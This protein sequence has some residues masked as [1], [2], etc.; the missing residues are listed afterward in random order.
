MASIVGFAAAAEFSTS[1]AAD[2]CPRLAALRNK[3]WGA[4][5]KSHPDSIRNGDTDRSL[6]NTLNVSFPGTDGEALLIGLDLEGVC[7]SSGSACMVGSIRASH[8]LLAMGVPSPTALATV[9]F[10]LGPSTTD[11][12]IEQAARSMLRVLEQQA[13]TVP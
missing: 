12:D 6:S 8:V 10:S 9:R 5:S 3:L 4:I 13:A 1:R 2:E 11:A 7:V